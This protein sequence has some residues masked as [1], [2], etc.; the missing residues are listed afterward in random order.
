MKFP[1]MRFHLGALAALALV[2]AV[3]SKAMPPPTP[4]SEQISKLLVEAKSHAVLAEDDAAALEAFTR[5]KL[6]WEAHAL[7]LQNIREHVNA[8]GQVSKEL[9]DLRPQ[10][11]PWQQKAIDQIDPPLREM[12]SR[13]TITINHLHENQ[14]KIHMKA[15]CDYAHGSYEL[16]ARTAGMI[17]DFVEYDKA[18]SLAESL[19][20]KLSLP[21]DEKSE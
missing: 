7:K 12:A 10:G 3:N 14:S 1:M 16:A 21:T 15:Y 11:S 6:S 13:L 19:E 17:R 5:S 8:L 18:K 2:F 9:T 20:A 4:D